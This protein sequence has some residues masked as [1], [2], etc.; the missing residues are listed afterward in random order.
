M[1]T[2]IK[3]VLLNNKEI[4]KEYAQE[5]YE[6]YVISHILVEAFFGGIAIV[7]PEGELKAEVT[8]I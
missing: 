5:L 1:Q 7:T 3:R 6:K 8:L 2:Q 4:S